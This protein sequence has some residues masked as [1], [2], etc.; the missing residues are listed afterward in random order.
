MARKRA[1]ASP[2][3]RT[4]I[5]VLGMHRSGTSA[6][7]RVVSLLGATAPKTLMPGDATNPRGFWESNKIVPLHEQMLAAAGSSWD[8]WQPFNPSW[9]QSADA[10]Q[11]RDRLASTITEEFGE[12]PVFV[13]KDPRICRFVPIWLDVLKQL[14]IRAAALHIVRNPLEV[15]YSLKARD[16]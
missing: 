4:A 8:D 11:M 16:G 12:A 14:N 2:R 5:L 6:L 13:V 3:G 10:T 7:A 9:Y 15:A 1:A